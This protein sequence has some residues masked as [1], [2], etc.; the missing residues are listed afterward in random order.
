MPGVVVDV[1][2][3]CT[4]NAD[5]ALS[6]ADLEAWEARHGR[7][8]RGALVCMRSGW[9]ARFG[10]PER[11]LNRGDDKAMHFPGFSGAAAEWL[12]RAREVAGV[13]V[14]TLSLDPGTSATFDCHRV[15]LGAD[16]F[17]VENM[18]F[19]PDLVSRSLA[20]MPT[21]LAQGA[22]HARSRRGSWSPCFR[23]ASSV[24]SRRPRARWPLRCRVPWMA[25]PRH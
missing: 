9:C 12:V 4:A 13:G 11:Y 18:N 15:M 3:Q 24:H 8:P 14:D 22:C 25:T 6:V 16:R 23:C 21:S 20:R 7:I 19:P 10:T 1:R 5:Y 17:Q 2:E